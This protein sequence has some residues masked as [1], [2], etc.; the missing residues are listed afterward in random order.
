VKFVANR[1][2]IRDDTVN[3][4]HTGESNALRQ[5]IGDVFVPVY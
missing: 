1:A 5:P 4:R 2:T 3:F